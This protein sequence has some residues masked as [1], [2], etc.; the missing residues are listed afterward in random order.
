VKLD[1]LQVALD[2]ARLETELRKA[3]SDVPCGAVSAGLSGAAAF[4]VS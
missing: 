3:I 4:H 1:R 2:T